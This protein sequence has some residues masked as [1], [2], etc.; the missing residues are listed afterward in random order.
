MPNE[1]T[2]IPPYLNLRCPACGYSLT[3]LKRWVCPECGG[4]FTPL[5]AWQANIKNTWD[6]HFAYHRPRWQYVMMGLTLIPALALL[7]FAAVV[8]KLAVFVSLLWVMPS[9]LLS[10]VIL[11]TCAANDWSGPWRWITIA[12]LCAVIA[13]LNSL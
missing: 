1:G 10:A 2:P 7:I 6:F 9:V 4:P 8:T 11:V 3:G 5:Q 12:Y 13:F